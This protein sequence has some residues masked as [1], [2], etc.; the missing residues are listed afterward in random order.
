M[1]G[2]DYIVE[3]LKAEG[4]HTLF[5]YPGGCIMPL[6]DAMIDS[7]IRHILCRHEQGAA[8]AANGYARA[9]G[10]T[11]VCLATSGPG[12][13]NL[14]TGIA[15]AYMDS[16]PMVAITGQVPTGLIGSDAF[17]EIDMLGL[18]LP[19]TKHSYLVETIEQLPGILDEAFVLASEGRPG[20]V[21]IDLPKD[22]QL[23][24]LPESVSLPGKS[25][26]PQ[27][28]PEP[29]PDDAIEQAKALMR[30]SEKPLIY[31][32]G[33]VTHAGALEAFRHFAE[34]S[35]IPA[36]CTLKGIGNL[37]AAHT[38]YMGMLGMHGSVAANNSVQECDLL[39]A[40]GARFDDRVTGKL[41]KFAPR[42]RVIHIDADAAEVGKLRAVECAIMSNL[43]T[44][45]DAL[46]M[47]LDIEPWRESCRQRSE[48]D[49]FAASPDDGV[50][51][52]ARFLK[53]LA[54]QAGERAIISCD[55]GQHQMW[56]AQHYPFAEPRNHLTSGGLGA[57]GFGLPA[58][59]G[60]ALGHPDRP[61]INIAGD[62]S[63]MMNLQ[64]MATLTRYSIPVKMI[65]MDNS[66]LG[67]VRQQQTL[68]YDNRQTEVD[69]SDNPDFA[70]IASSF[71]IRAERL[72]DP[73]KTAEAIDR[74]LAEP[75]PVPLHLTIAAS[76]DVW[77][78]V[79]PGDANDEMIT[80]NSIEGAAA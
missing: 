24:S 62:G 37:P 78:M 8:F 49:G 73:G 41:E 75:G 64:E 3:K 26:A 22:V 44:A 9:T 2:A 10:R 16:I 45:L 76:E 55:V 58:A 25:G 70:A 56:V 69:L 34:T 59:I 54:K 50:L 63:F 57:M 7:G 17:Q 60:A 71:G 68:C 66:R 61:V 13:T 6:Y 33:G 5:G 38:L 74:L 43:A 15:D 80:S 12:A 11:G 53:A 40:I 18:S 47:P 72:E 30:E 32:G 48:R 65:I 42:A 4:I 31:A 67:M 1:N 20:P 79:K 52:P 51:N 29:L 77:P 23:Q 35:G 14:I 28:T 19:I 21:L 36:V 39:I 27:N 46:A